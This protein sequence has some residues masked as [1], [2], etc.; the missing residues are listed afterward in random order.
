MK[1]TDVV[2]PV[3]ERDGKILATQ[4]G[5]GDMAGG[6]EFHGGKIEPGGTPEEALAREMSMVVA[7]RWIAR[8]QRRN[9]PCSELMVP[10][11]ALL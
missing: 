11:I 6:W 9:A 5:Y 10:T 7:C 1:A 8:F 3:T 4:R 2:A